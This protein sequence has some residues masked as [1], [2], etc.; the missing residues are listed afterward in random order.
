MLCFAREMGNYLIWFAT[1]KAVTL[2]NAP[3]KNTYWFYP[4]KS[5]DMQSLTAS[6]RSTSLS[7]VYWW[8]PGGS[9]IHHS[10]R[11]GMAWNGR[12]LMSG[13][14]P[15]YGDPSSQHT[16][17]SCSA[18]PPAWGYPAT[19]LVPLNLPSVEEKQR[20]GACDSSRQPGIGNS[21]GILKRTDFDFST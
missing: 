5:C 19:K 3:K 16:E 12:S 13:L 18:D 8:L 20:V 15:K 17:V 14:K 9:I 11:V 2:A 4:V 7:G 6:R 10:S 1:N 21:F